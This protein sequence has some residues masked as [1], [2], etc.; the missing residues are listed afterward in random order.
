MRATI[1]GKVARLNST[2][3]AVY[4]WSALVLAVMSISSLIFAQGNGAREQ[5]LC[6]VQHIAQSRVASVPE[7]VKNRHKSDQRGGRAVTV[8]V[9][10]EIRTRP[11]GERPSAIAARLCEQ[12]TH[13]TGW[14]PGRNGDP[15]LAY[16]AFESEDEREQF[17]TGALNVPGVSIAEP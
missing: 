3:A 7:C 15:A 10:L 8:K 13:L 4:A 9:T 6:A 5:L 16:F 14:R 1:S 11:D 12:S 2:T 17:L